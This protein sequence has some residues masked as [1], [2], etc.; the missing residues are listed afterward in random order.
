ML[1]GY[2]TL[3]FWAVVVSKKREGENGDNDE[4]AFHT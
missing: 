2:F 4:D 3:H 1:T